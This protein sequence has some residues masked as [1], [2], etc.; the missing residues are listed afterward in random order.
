[1]EE[2][3][4]LKKS[5]KNKTQIQQLTEKAKAV[6]RNYKKR[7][8]DVKI[9]RDYLPLKIT[10]E[11]GECLQ[12]FLMLT[13]RGRQKR[14]SKKEIQKLFSEEFADIFAY[15]LIFA[16]NEGVDIV[17]SLTKKWFKYLENRK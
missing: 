4:T 13:D 12:V 9:G 14:M 6:M 5:E 11:W 8:P 3:M 17:E 10:E 7:Y 16:D 15:L 2:K 1:M